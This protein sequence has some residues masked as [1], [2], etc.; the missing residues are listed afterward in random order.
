MIHR[1]HEGDSHA[2]TLKRQRN[3]RRNKAAKLSRRKNRGRG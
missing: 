3:R 2:H 1:R